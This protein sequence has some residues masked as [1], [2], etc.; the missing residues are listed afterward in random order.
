M[1][2]MQPQILHQER[3]DNHAKPIMHV[4]CLPKLTHRRINNGISRLSI[5]PA[6]Q[7]IRILLPRKI[8]KFWL[9]VLTWQIRI[10]KQQRIG[11]FPPTQFRKEIIGINFQ[12][13]SV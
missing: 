2:P 13:T 12:L 4:T 9:K 1:L 10:V 3:A 6:A 7:K 11:K 8:I 5:L